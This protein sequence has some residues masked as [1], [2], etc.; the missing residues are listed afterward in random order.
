MIRGRLVAVNGRPWPDYTEERAKRLVDREFNLSNAQ[1]PAAQP[2]RGRPLDRRRGRRR[3][4]GRRHCQDPG[5]EAGRPL[6]F[7]IGGVQNEAR[8]TSLRKV[9]WGSMR[10]NF[11]VMYPVQQPERAITY[12]AAYRA[13]EGGL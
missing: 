10:A 11:F 12:L 6:R 7:D 8:I 3:Q 1:Q 5:P 4:R 13:P 2:D 9:D